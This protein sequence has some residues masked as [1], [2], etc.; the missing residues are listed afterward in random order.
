MGCAKTAIFLALFLKLLLIGANSDD[1]QR[2]N[3]IILLIDGYGSDL[4]NKTDPKLQDAASELIRNGV[5]ADM[6]PVFP[7]QSYPNWYS[8]ATGL[9]V[10][11]HNM[12]S[13]FMYDPERHVF[14]Q[15]DQGVNDTDYQWWT[16]GPDPFYYTVG[17]AGID[18]HCHL[19]SS[20]H[21]PHVDM[22]I[23]VPQNRQHSFKN[24][25]TYDLFAHIPKIMR[26]VSRYQQY[27]QQLVLLN[28][29]NL[30]KTLRLF[31]ENSDAGKQALSSADAQIRKIQ[32]AMVE[33]DLFSTT[34]LLVLSSFGLK[35]ISEEQQYFIE[36]CFADVSKVKRVVNSLS[37]M[38]VYPEEGQ[39]DTVYF[40]LRVCDQWAMES[41]YDEN[42]AQL[43]SVYRK[44]EIP[45]RYHWKHARFISPI[46]LIARP[47]AIL[48]TSQIPSTEIS[49]AQ[50][51][52]LRMLS[53]WDNED[54]QMQGLFL[55]RGPAFKPDYISPPI[56]IVDVYELSLKLLG[57][58][59]KNP[60][61]GTWENVA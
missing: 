49:E 16:G 55:A 8:L 30:A 5:R 14:F 34:N 32:D 39:E 43:V 18:V 27:R 33:H 31:G 24:E 25:D 60:H 1:G 53:G 51:R 3:L 10:E 22:L 61:N 20:C 17:R 26:H 7:T 58:S 40:E 21:R 38:F 46:V 47:G 29:P 44:A 56:E 15:R 50:G 48:L 41:D 52:E 4:F 57:L 11:N 19:F 35:E 59:A 45:E 12:T 54:V 13:D 9:Y 37:H 42:E 23:K 28:Y 2:H 36:E 6:K